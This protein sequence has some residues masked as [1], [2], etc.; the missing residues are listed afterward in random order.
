V[1]VGEGHRGGLDDRAFLVVAMAI[2]GAAVLQS[3]VHL[4]VVLGERDLHSRFDLDR[5]NGV[6]DVVSNLVLACATAGAAALA[7]HQRGRGRIAPACLVV[8]LGG[9]TIADL[10]H[11]GAHLSS[12]TGRL[13]VGL[14]AVTGILLAAVA[15]ESAG[16]TRATLG[17]A[18]VVLAGSFLV[19]GLDHFDIWFERKRG[20][21]VAEYQIVAKE[22]LEL[23]GWSLVALALWDETVRRRR[24]LSVVPPIATEGTALSEEGRG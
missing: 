13:V 4:V 9:L 19:S 8:A 11:D 5:S 17:V 22:G 7:W 14:V 23:I 3:M 18:A 12:H 1:T 24:S 15:V 20:D 10:L 6:P 2:L 16:R 21:P